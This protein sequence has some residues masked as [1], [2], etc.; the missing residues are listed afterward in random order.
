MNPQATGKTLVFE[1]ADPD[2]GD[3]HTTV[4][5]GPGELAVWLPERF[6]ERY[7]VLGQDH[8]ASGARYRGDGVMVWTHG[9]EAMLEVDGQ[10]FTGCTSAP[11]LVSWED[12]RRRGVDFRGLGQEPG[13]YLELREA[14]QILFVYDYGQRRVRFPS[15]E[16]SGRATGER[17]VYR[18]SEGTDDLTVA[19][20][21]ERCTDSM[22]G[23]QFEYSVR[24]RLNENTYRGCGREL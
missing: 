16:L 24:V 14:E 8:A 2:G 19:I 17:R 22:S 11:R 13:W 23:H 21:A 6:G 4:R 9:D 10:S 5:T 18:A 7:L 20:V 1:C 12:A 15:P 3:F